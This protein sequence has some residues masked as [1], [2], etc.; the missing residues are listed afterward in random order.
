MRVWFLNVGHGD[1]TII[2]HA[3][4]RI[5]MVDINNSQ[6]YDPESREELVEEQAAAYGNGFLSRYLAEAAVEEAEAQELTDPVAFFKKTFGNQPVF[7]FILTHPDL[8]H[9]RGLANL[10]R[11]V[12]VLNFW[13]T[14]NTK[15]TPSYRSSADKEDWEFY[16]A[17]RSGQVSGVGVPKYYHRGD[18][19][20][21]FAKDQSGGFG[22]DELEILSPTSQIVRTCNGAGRSNDLS[23]VLRVSYAGRSLLLPGDAESL[24][25]GAMVQHYG[26]ALRADALKAS[27]HGRL[28]GFDL[29]AL[30]LIRPR[31]VVLSVGRKPSTD[32]QRRYSNHCARAISTRRHGNISCRVDANGNWAWTAERNTDT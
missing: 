5:T 22:G 7:R 17:L 26:K 6:D 31:F 23:T 10:F 21:A 4:G 11:N 24:A 3:S 19:L 25:W 29:D 15:P 27:H 1:C 8:D 14:R 18:A 9:M 32:A 12:P 28:S 20:F 30:K 13:D 2:Q 16:Q